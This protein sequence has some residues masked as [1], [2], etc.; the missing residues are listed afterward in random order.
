MILK[1]ADALNFVVANT[2]FKKNDGRLITYKTGK[3]RTVT[4]YILIRK[5]ERKL[6]RDVK[7]VQQKQCIPSRK[8]IICVLDL[9][10]GQYKCKME[11]VKR[12]KVWKLR[13]DGTAGIFKER[14]QT[15]AALVVEKPTGV[16]E[17]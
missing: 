4:D 2:W 17:V 3:C 9:K 5:S 11:F 14:V 6:I 12:Y 15:R 7:V 13:D 16:E 8:L 10:D 1:F